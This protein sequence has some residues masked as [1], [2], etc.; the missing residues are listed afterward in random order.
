VSQLRSLVTGFPLWHS[1]FEPGLG[2][3]GFV[4][5]NV[6]LGLVSFKYFGFPCQFSF[7]HLL[8]SHL[9]QSSGAGTIG[10]IVAD[11][12][13]GISLTPPKEKR[14]YEIK[15]IVMQCALKCSQTY[16]ANV[17]FCQF[18]KVI[19]FRGR[20]INDIWANILFSPCNNA[21]R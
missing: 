6:V 8:H 11:V 4:V 2:H 21:L 14:S 12:P 20:N 19:I 5:D 18:P 1:V 10:Q 9:H 15:Y 3:V 16:H 13:N 7:H 17:T